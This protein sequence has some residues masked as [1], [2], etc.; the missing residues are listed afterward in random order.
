MDL[1]PAA[2]TFPA[3]LGAS[4]NK[5]CESRVTVGFPSG[6]LLLRTLG[7]WVPLGIGS[8]ALLPVLGPAFL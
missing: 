3:A 1:E 7:V 4:R 6:M 5:S 2:G 8:G